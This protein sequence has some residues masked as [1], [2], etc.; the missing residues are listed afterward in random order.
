MTQREQEPG[1]LE[2]S[3]ARY[4]QLFEASAAIQLIVD[5]ETG[6]L[7]DV[8]AAAESFYGWPRPTMRTMLITDLDGRTLDAWRGDMVAGSADASGGIATHHHRIARGARRT[9]EIASSPLQ[10]DGRAARHLIVHDVSDRVRAETRLRESE[11]RYRAVIN[12]MS[13]GVVVHDATGA[14]RGFN[15]EAERILG[16][17]AAELLGLQPVA[18]DWS[19]VHE[20]GTAWPPA[21]H[22]AMQ[23]LRTGRHQPRT[24]MGIRR[25]KGEA[26]W[27]HV[28]A[29]PLLRDGEPAPFGAVAVFSDV[30][31]QRHAEERLRQAQK[32]E[33]VGQLAGGIAHDF[34]NLLTVIRGAS[35]FL[36][37]SL[38][39]ES[40]QQEDVRAIERAADRA[41]ELT[42]RLL[43]VGRRQLLRP[44][45]V[46]LSALLRDQFATIRDQSPRSIRVELALS[47]NRVVARLDRRMLLDALRA[48]VDNARSAM[49]SGGTLT[50]ATDVREAERGTVLPDR[51]DAQR[52]A[53][54]EVRDTGAG[55]S[56]E[57]RARLF[58]PFFSTQPFGASH[59]MGLASVH[60]M[61]AQSH[62]FIECDTAVGKGT[63]LRLFFPSATEAE[64]ITTPPSGAGAIARRG[65]LLV[66]DDPMLRDL[67]TRMLERLGHSVAVMDTGAEALAL[68]ASGAVQ[69]SVL[70][71]DLT[72]PGMNG[73]ELIAEVARR[74][75]QLPIVAIS[76]FS[77]NPA[78]RQELADRRVP[79]VG[80][81]FAAEDLE[82]AMDQAQNNKQQTANSEMGR[83]Q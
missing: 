68:L 65:V 5:E 22:P 47:A 49:P 54:L 20:D 12:A 38:D 52:F 63:S 37:D 7:I 66:D 19:A 79:F 4:R 29:D 62:G 82:K 43:A 34:N 61:V 13:E 9:V 18:R 45:P 28:S 50:L 76:G 69:L 10:L 15:P 83:V 59:G 6:A 26:A 73:M 25:G 51:G 72:M 14:I 11:A 41:E 39:S 67:A 77:M 60:G 70:V 30:T 74:H 33:A 16:L 64:R 21:E 81:P 32:L 2:A 80:K 8:N 75:P 17:S 55:M 56:E 44:E 53:M 1:A 42:R 31:R 35:S 46:D 27:L 3:E 40:P 78:V 71:T 48:L 57:V 58:E 24:L 36:R 23:A